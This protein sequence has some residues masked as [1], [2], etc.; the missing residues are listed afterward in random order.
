M[1]DIEVLA[2]AGS[3]ESMEAAVRAGADAVYMGGAKFG[4][5]AYAENPDDTG[6]LRAIDFV[7]L[8]GR[9]LYLT[10]NTLLKERELTEELWKYLAP[11]Y[12]QGL[13][14]VIVQDYG[15]LSFIRKHFPKMEI[16]I[17]TQMAVAGPY[18]AM[19][20]K[21]LGA[22]RLVLPRELSLAEIR[23]IREKTDLELEGFVHGALCYCYS[24]QCL[25]SSFIGGRSG[26]RGRCAQPCRLP[27]NG[28][29]LMN[30]KD[31]CTLAILP[32]ILEAGVTSLK[33][34]GRMKSP[35]YTAGVV[36]IYRKYVDRYLTSGG[37][38]WQ[39]DP[40]D[41]R[42]L[43]ELFD[44]GG[45]TD[46]YYRRHNGA[47]MVFTGKKP[48][49][50]VI[51]EERLRFLDEQYLQGEIKEKIKGK[52]KILKGFPATIEVTWGDQ[53]VSVFGDVVA[54]AKNRPLE[55]EMVFR[56]MDKMG[57][58]GF[59]WESLEIEM[60]EDVFLPMGAINGL[61]RSA[62]EAIQ[63]ARCHAYQRTL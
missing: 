7:H 43:K 48:E 29:N 15:V 62:V 58:S 8:H 53:S 1:T 59:V 25:L 50:R 19:L 23:A 27:Y 52:V 49:L 28:K 31:L 40:E 18:G 57:G 21:E 44:R 47:D 26:N 51:D 22:G 2:P 46:G 41:E 12:R 36:S 32:Q 10:V 38:D 56:Q 39:V 5:R 20:A 9:K 17:S 3:Y 45:F 6:L 54:E 16:H 37:G 60:D 35:R 14:A 63:E 61:R 4:A 55:K 11:L 13:D 34:E 33:I 30:L 24:G 42:L